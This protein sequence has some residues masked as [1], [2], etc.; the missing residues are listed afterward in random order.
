[1]EVAKIDRLLAFWQQDK[2][3]ITLL[4]DICDAICHS[5]DSQ[6]LFDI[7]NLIPSDIKNSPE[8]VGLLGWAFLRLS[9]FDDA[10]GYFNQLADNS[11]VR[12]NG[13]ATILYFQ[14][15]F[16]E[17]Q[18]LLNTFLSQNEHMA[19]PTLVILQ[20]RCSYFLGDLDSGYNLLETIKADNPAIEAERLGLLAML[21]VDMLLM[22]DAEEAANQA[23]KLN[24]RNHDALL[25][26]ASVL[27]HSTEYSNAKGLVEKGKQW[28]PRSGRFWLLDAQIRMFETNIAD[29][30]VSAST[31]VEFMPD[32]IGSWHI[33]AWTEL[34]QNQFSDALNS[35]DSA[36]SL[37][38][39]FAESHGGKAVALF[40]LG[41][42][43]EATK[44]TQVALRLDPNCVTGAYALSLQERINGDAAKAQQTIESILSRTSHLGDGVPYIKL[45]E[46]LNNNS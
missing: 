3:N 14:R 17:A 23:L 8:V 13:L 10:A 7:V 30:K 16:K 27:M 39:N 9:R 5:G 26:M 38:R 11:S 34:L 1:M 42:I 43:E 25:A 31:A 4:S 35:F 36:L 2:S 33:K 44:C 15:Q 29:A 12:V 24:N 19:F 28:F 21:C 22:P 40:Q 20:A 18:A 32:H 41:Q 37:N 6:R 46:K 45:I